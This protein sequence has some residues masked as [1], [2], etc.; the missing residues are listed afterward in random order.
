M[1]K[2]SV[3]LSNIP[4]VNEGLAEFMQFV[5]DILENQLDSD[6]MYERK[7]EVRD[8]TNNNEEQYTGSVYT[9][10]IHWNGVLQTLRKVLSDGLA[11]ASNG[12]YQHGKVI[13][14]KAVECR[15]NCV[16]L[17]YCRQ[18]SMEPYVTINIKC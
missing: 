8:I 1:S 11:I 17:C 3:T 6:G 9:F 18:I 13:S 12:E 16:D 7:V 2:V 4:L 14:V 10:T 15:Q 5:Q